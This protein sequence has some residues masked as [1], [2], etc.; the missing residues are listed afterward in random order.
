MQQEAPQRFSAVGLIFFHGGD[1][2]IGTEQLSGLPVPD[3]DS[4][5]HSWGKHRWLAILRPQGEARHPTIPK[6]H[7]VEED[8]DYGL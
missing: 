5:Q 8:L 7:H 4:R 6:E 3:R 1:G 2:V